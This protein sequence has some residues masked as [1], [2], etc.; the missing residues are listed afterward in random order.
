MRP[1]G[2]G[3]Q[4]GGQQAAVATDSRTNERLVKAVGTYAVLGVGFV[5]TLFLTAQFAGSG[6]SGGVGGGLLGASGAAAGFALAVVLSPL[7]A[8]VIGTEIG[9]DGGDDAVVDAGIAT[10]VGFVVMFF[11]TMVLAASL[12]GGST[13]GTA[14][15]GPLVGLGVGV[16]ITGAASAAVARWEQSFLDAVANPPLVKSIVFGSLTYGVFAVGYAVA[17]VLA[18]A[19]SG[20]GGGGFGAIG[21]GSGALGALGLGLVLA[22]LLA[23]LVGFFAGRDGLETPGQAAISGGVGA[24][25]GTLLLTVL[26]LVA[27]AILSPTGQ[28]PI[29]AGP[30]VGLTVGAGLTGAGAGYVGGR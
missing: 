23:V 28:I 17:I 26:M 11:L 18:G 9:R 29:P 10:G 15:A 8:I 1:D 3:V 25:V 30:I 22:P 27:V 19:L 20:G 12:S 21:G 6:G 24:A 2:T 5:F 16:A 14:Q 7:I 4:T 13:G